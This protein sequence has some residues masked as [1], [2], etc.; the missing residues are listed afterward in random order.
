MDVDKCC[1]SQV[2]V[3]V[4]ADPCHGVGRPICWDNLREL[5]VIGRSVK[6]YTKAAGEDWCEVMTPTLLEAGAAQCKEGIS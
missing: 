6:S 1:V 5:V 3:S 4:V 2:C